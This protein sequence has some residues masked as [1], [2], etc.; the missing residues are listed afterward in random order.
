M[1]LKNH[2]HPKRVRPVIHASGSNRQNTIADGRFCTRCFMS[3][4]CGQRVTSLFF[5]FFFFF[6]DG[7]QIIITYVRYRRINAHCGPIFIRKTRRRVFIALKLFST[8]NLNFSNNVMIPT[9]FY[10]SRVDTPGHTN[11]V[12]KLYCKLLIIYYRDYMSVHGS[13]KIR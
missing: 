11:S 13:C 12:N 8:E 4:D 5:C 10:E 2:L 3:H 6:V 9:R 1:T 7:A